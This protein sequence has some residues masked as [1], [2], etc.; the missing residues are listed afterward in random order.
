MTGILV[1]SHRLGKTHFRLLMLGGVCILLVFIFVSVYRNSSEHMDYY[2][3][4]SGIYRG[5]A[6]DLTSTELVRYFGMNQRN[7]TT[8]LSGGFNPED[9]LEY[10]FSPVASVFMDVP[11]GLGTSIYG[12]T[13]NNIIAYAYHDAGWAMWAL[14]FI[15][16]IIINLTFIRFSQNRAS[17]TRAYWWSTMG[18]SLTMSFFAYLNAYAYWMFLFPIVVWLIQA[19]LARTKNESVA[20]KCDC[21]ELGM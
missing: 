16:S 15:W 11:Q 3:I 18:M 10:T 19:L 1:A 13:A 8:V 7:M 2:Y 21:I 17:I 20:S 14:I 9:A 4:S 12:Y 6:S 5:E